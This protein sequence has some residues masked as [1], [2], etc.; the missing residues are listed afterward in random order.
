VETKSLSQVRGA[1]LLAGLGERGELRLG[2]EWELVQ[3]SVQIA[4][5]I[6]LAYSWAYPAAKGYSLDS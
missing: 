6:L 1:V 3:E 5:Y 4:V 2:I